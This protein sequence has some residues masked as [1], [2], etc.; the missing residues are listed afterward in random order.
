VIDIERATLIAKQ[1]LADLQIDGDISLIFTRVQEEK[2]G[3][4]FFYNSREYIETGNLSA[5]LAGNS[6]FIVDYENWEVHVLGTAYPTETYIEEYKNQKTK[7]GLA[8]DFE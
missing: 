3:C 5:A 4:V 6:P 7:N 1:Y 2:F 8:R